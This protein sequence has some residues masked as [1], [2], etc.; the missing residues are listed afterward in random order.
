MAAVTDEAK[1]G[2][3]M[4]RDKPLYSKLPGFLF[5]FLLLFSVFIPITQVQSQTQNINLNGLWKSST[6]AIIDIRQSGGG[7][8][9]G[10]I[11][12]TGS[13]SLNT[14]STNVDGS[15][16]NN[17]FAGNIYLRALTRS[18]SFLDG[19]YPATGIGSPD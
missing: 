5:G 7:G 18:C 11:K 16:K 14:G 4:I 10:L 2:E 15:I 8:L 19:L 13:S 9:V 12:Q 1:K 17:T 3:E 6:G